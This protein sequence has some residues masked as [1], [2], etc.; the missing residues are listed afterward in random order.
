MNKWVKFSY[1]SLLLA[2]ARDLHDEAKREDSIDLMIKSGILH[3]R[4]SQLMEE[5][6]PV[7]IHRGN[8]GKPNKQNKKK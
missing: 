1:A 8:Y 5:I 7:G 3:D 6:F 2:K 4:A